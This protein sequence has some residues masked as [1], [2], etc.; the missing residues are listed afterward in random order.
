MSKNETKEEEVKE[1]ETETV[2]KTVPEK[3]ANFQKQFSSKKLFLLERDKELKQL[4][5]AK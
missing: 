2:N 3:T 1:K 5:Y 4:I